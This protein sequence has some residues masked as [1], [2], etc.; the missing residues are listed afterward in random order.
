MTKKELLETKEWY[1]RQIEKDFARW[2]NNDLYLRITAQCITLADE[3]CYNHH[4]RGQR[5]WAYVQAL[6]ELGVIPNGR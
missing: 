4:E 5:L 6:R 1:K 3:A 2:G